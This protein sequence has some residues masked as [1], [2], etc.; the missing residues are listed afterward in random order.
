MGQFDSAA[1]AN[2]Q[3]PGNIERLLE[4]GRDFFRSER[5]GPASR[6]SRKNQMTGSN[7]M[8]L[9]AGC[10]RVLDATMVAN[11]RWRP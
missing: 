7:G 5:R 9:A 8:E 4:Q 11:A 3:Q 10:H 2:C 1:Q 6:P